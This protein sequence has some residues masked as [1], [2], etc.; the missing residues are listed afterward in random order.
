MVKA[1]KLVNDGFSLLIPLWPRKAV[2]L[3]PR[4]AGLV[5]K[6]KEWRAQES[7]RRLASGFIKSQDSSIVVSMSKK[8]REREGE[9]EREREREREK[10]QI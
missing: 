3:W 2:S 5:V 8:K 10:T 1:Q 6:V 4:K 9:R 7:R